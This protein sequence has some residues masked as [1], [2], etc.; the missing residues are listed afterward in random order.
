MCRSAPQRNLAEVYDAICGF[1]GMEFY[2]R[3][4][5]TLAGLTWGEAIVRPTR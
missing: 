3:A 1:D 5:P 4:W 2:F